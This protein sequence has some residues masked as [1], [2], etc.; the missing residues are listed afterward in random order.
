MIPVR[1]EDAGGEI[2][3][4]SYAQTASGPQLSVLA[5]VRYQSGPPGGAPPG[6][7][8]AGLASA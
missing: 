6:R 8:R 2:C 4:M 3:L 1:G 5:R 7:G